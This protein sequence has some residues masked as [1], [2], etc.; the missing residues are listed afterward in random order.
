M[1]RAWSILL[2]LAA[3]MSASRALGAGFDVDAK[4]FADVTAVQGDRPFTVAVVLT[5]PEGWHIYWKNPGDSGLPTKIR[6]QPPTG[7]SVG[8]MEFPIPQR[9]VAAAD[10][11]NYGYEGPTVFL[12]PITPPHDLAKGATADLKLNVSW[13]VCKEEC[14][15]GRATLALSL[16]LGESSPANADLFAKARALMPEATVPQD[17]VASIKSQSGAFGLQIDWK[18][19]PTNVQVFPLNVDGLSVSPINAQTTGVQS[20]LPIQAHVM[21]GQTL[22]TEQL[23]LLISLTDSSGRTRGFYTDVDLHALAAHGSP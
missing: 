20:L 5:P 4:V 3:G 9:L 23:P 8:A 13:L 18:T 2:L 11:I 17:E 21:S 7:F 1:R 19:A 15:P 10:I 12:I 14:V 6:V 22:K 16:P